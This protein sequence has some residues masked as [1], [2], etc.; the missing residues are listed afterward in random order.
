[1]SSFISLANL[2]ITNSLQSAPRFRWFA[3]NRL[4]KT[5]AFTV[6]FDRRF[7]AD[8]QNDFLDERVG[9]LTIV[10]A[11]S[12]VVAPI[13]SQISLILRANWSNPPAHGARTVAL[14]LTTPDLR[15]QWLDSIKVKRLFRKSLIIGLEI[16]A[17]VVAY[18]GDAAR[19]AL[20]SRELEDAGHMGSRHEAD[21]NVSRQFLQASMNQTF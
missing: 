13:K 17:N 4:L 8:A 14:I 16:L 6:S 11:D 12:K 3:L 7:Y 5:S 19:V 21:W 10:A 9:N 20:A 18:H 2:T 15:R 1:M